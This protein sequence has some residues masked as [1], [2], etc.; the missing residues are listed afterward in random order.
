MPMTVTEKI[1]AR[2]S[3]RDSVIPGDIVQAELDWIMTNDA[4]THVSIDIFKSKLRNA[5]IRH[6]DR[7]IWVVDHNIPAECIETANVQKKQRDFAEQQGFRIHNGEG[8]CHQLLVEQYVLPGQVVIGAD[9]HTCT[10]GALGAFA[11]GVGSTDLV[12]AMTEGVLWFMVPATLRFDLEGALAR[13]VTTKDLVLRIA[14]DITARG[15]TYRAMEY[16]GPGLRGLS[17]DSRLALANLAVEVGAKNA[18]MPVDDVVGSFLHRTRGEASVRESLSSDSNAVY[19]RVHTYRLDE[20]EPV[21]AFPHT[22]DNVKPIKDAL[23]IRLDQVFIGSCS[24]GR[25]E[26]LRIA[27]DILRGR[28]IAK[29]LRLAIAP[30]SREVYLDALAAGYIETYLQAGAMVL[31]PNCSTCWGGGQAVVGDGERLLSTGTRNFKGRSGSATAEVYLSSV[32]TAAASALAGEIVD[33]R[34]YLHLAQ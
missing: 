18:I 16:A 13:G 29:N 14:G 32:Y 23:G 3:G 24:N 28:R 21:V 10:H 7:V 26:D 22:V 8:V 9:S 11:T 25:L 27:A 31:N 12:A 20:I 6:P 19:E 1:L 34:H 17:L 4:T 33:P 2:A 5:A 30:A 15:A